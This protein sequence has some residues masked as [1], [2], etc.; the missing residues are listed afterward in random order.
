[1]KISE[2]HVY[3]HDL[4]VKDGPYTIASSTV[5]SLQTTLVKIVTENGLAGWGETCPVGPRPA[6]RLVPAPP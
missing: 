2:I 5:W 3:T 4:P 1:M 6:M